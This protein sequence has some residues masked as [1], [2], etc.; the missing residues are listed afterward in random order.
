M[1]YGDLP[2][3]SY[4]RNPAPDGHRLEEIALQFYLGYFMYLSTY[5]VLK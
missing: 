1:D 2:Q 4:K 3:L 5:T